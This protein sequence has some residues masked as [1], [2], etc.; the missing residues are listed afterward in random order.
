MIGAAAPGRSWLIAKAEIETPMVPK[1]RPMAR[2]SRASR[3]KVGRSR[4]D[5]SPRACS[6]GT[7]RGA[8]RYWAASA[9][10]PPTIKAAAM[11]LARVV[12]PTAP[13]AVTS[14]GPRRKAVALASD[15]KEKA[16]GSSLAR[17]SRSR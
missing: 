13:R 3:R 6:P 14:T 11:A 2:L 15:S 4:E 17:S 12:L 1:Y 5:R 8:V 16:L 9:A 7:G 10:P